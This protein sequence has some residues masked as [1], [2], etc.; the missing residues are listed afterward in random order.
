MSLSAELYARAQHRAGNDE[1]IMLDVPA[2]L[3]IEKKPGLA[4]VSC[5]I[6]GKSQLVK[7]MCN[8]VG[9]HILYAMHGIRECDIQNLGV[10][11]CGFCGWDGCMVQ[12]TK[13]NSGVSVTSSCPYHYMLMSYNSAKTVSKAT[14]CTNVPIHCPLCP[15][16]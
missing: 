12:L 10:E 6:C 15:P 2:W 7:N 4:A 8:H 11:P 16:G 1:L 14:P 5:F 13:K 9:H 3:T